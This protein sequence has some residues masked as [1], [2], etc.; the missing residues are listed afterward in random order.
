MAETTPR[1]RKTSDEDE[2]T[3]YSVFNVSNII[4]SPSKFKANT[5][6]DRCEFGVVSADNNVPKRVTCYSTDL[7]EYLRKSGVADDENLAIPLEMEPNSAGFTF[8]PNGG[9]S[10][11]QV[12]KLK[13]P[14]E[15]QHAPTVSLFDVKFK[16]KV[17]TSHSVLVTVVRCHQEFNK[18]CCVWQYEVADGD[19]K[20]CLSSF[21]AVNLKEGESYHVYDVEIT[22]FNNKRQLR[23]HAASSF[24]KSDNNVEIADDDDDQRIIKIRSAKQSKILHCS[25]C[26][27]LVPPDNIADGMYNCTNCDSNA[28]VPELP[29][30]IT[31]MSSNKSQETFK[32]PEVFFQEQAGASMKVLLTTEFKI[33]ADQNNNIT[34]FTPVSN[35]K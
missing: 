13:N 23:F 18:K 7:H 22:E 35:Q 17:N 30:E 26:S 21:N 11:G 20:I 16:L 29:M 28:L 19:T 4:K 15:V 31:C 24:Q 14:H 33:R 2:R 9:S 34:S 12:V 5:F 1:K 27:E 3:L 8:N 25:D 6:Y 10:F 32:L